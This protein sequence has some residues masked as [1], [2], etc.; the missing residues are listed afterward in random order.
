MLPV[1]SGASAM[2]QATAFVKNYGK[3]ASLAAPLAAKIQSAL[4]DVTQN[5]MASNSRRLLRDGIDAAQEVAE[6]SYRE[7]PLRLDESDEE[8]E[9]SLSD[10]DNND[11]WEPRLPGLQDHEVGDDKKVNDG[12]EKGNYPEY[13]EDLVVHVMIGDE[14]EKERSGASDWS[15]TDAMELVDEFCDRH[16]LS[17]SKRRLLIDH[18]AQHL[19]QVVTKTMCLSVTIMQCDNECVGQLEMESLDD[20][21]DRVNVRFTA[22]AL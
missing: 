13:L 7:F 14:D 3:S 8:D 6:L 11:D 17:V 4:D 1:R 22:D 16:Q 10:G 12:P 15:R 9:Q 2:V 20:V 21:A 18:V 19:P 5:H